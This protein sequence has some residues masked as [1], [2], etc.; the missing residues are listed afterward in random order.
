MRVSWIVPSFTAGGIGPVCRYTAESVAR[1]T[2]WE[3]TL[4]SVHDE[5]AAADGAAFGVR[6][7]ALGLDVDTAR[8]FLAWLAGNPQDVVVTSNVGGVE[9]AY[10]YFPTQTLHIEQLHDS[11]RRYRQ[12]ATRHA[13]W[14][15]GVTCVGRFYEAKLRR[16]LAATGWHGLLRTIHNGA[17]FPPLLPRREAPDRLRLLFIGRTEPQKGALD[18]PPLLG[19]LRRLGVPAHLTIVGGDDPQ[20]RQQ[21]DRVGLADAVSWAGRVPH[22]ECYRF[23]AD[24]DVV[25]M[26][27]R[28][29]AFGMVTIEGMSMGCV[30]V[31][32]DMPSGS[33]EIIEHGVSG[34][35]VPP[36]SLRRLARAIA[37]LHVDRAALRRLSDG[38][39]ARA[40]SAFDIGVTAA[41][42]E[43]FIRDVAAHAATHPAQ[44]LDGLPPASA[45]SVMSP[46]RQGYQRL[47]ESW[48]VAA[49][50]WLCRFPRLANLVYNR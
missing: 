9:P 17:A 46:P 6:A 50:R 4:V 44:R 32:Y 13:R 28:K 30:P 2:G 39:I 45:G 10:P 42:M 37:A 47:P 23:A 26:L 22:E 14:L 33:T 5:P 18:L 27:S 19:T 35:L 1:R 21:F 7:V 43:A 34:L 31:A 15:D 11:A 49:H 40:R 8:G 24:S 20:L 38:A 41:N 12:I 29:E 3:V 36:G 25:L 48:R 16:E